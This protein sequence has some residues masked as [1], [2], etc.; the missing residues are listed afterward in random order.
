MKQVHQ[1]PDGMVFVRVD[2]ATYGDTPDNFLSD[3]GFLLPELPE[4]M[5]ERIYDQN[6]RHVFAGE[7]DTGAITSGGEMPWPLGDRA[8]LDIEAG[9][10]S[11]AA[12]RVAEEAAKPP[13]PKPGPSQRDLIA[14]DHENR[15]RALEGKPAISASD[16]FIGKKI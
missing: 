14:F 8:I 9:L 11:Q 5:N 16:F 6:R 7:N 4:G 3:F 1:H 13:A 2:G 15:L 12:R 10:S